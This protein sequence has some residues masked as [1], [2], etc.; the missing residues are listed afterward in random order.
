MII[1]ILKLLD[2]LSALADDIAT[3]TKIASEKTVAILGDDLAVNAEQ[4]TGFNQDKELKVIWEITKGSFKNKLILLPIIFILNYYLPI[5]ISFLLI[6]GGL[7]LL[8]EGIE[9]IYE[10]I[11]IK[12]LKKEKKINLLNINKLKKNINLEEKKIKSAIKTDFILSIEIIVITLGSV[13]NHPF[14]VQVISTTIVS[15][16]ATIF[17]YGIVALIVRIDNLGFYFIK[18]KAVKL[19]QFFIN[20]MSI[21]IKILSVVGTIAMILVGGNILTHKIELF[22]TYFLSFLPFIINEFILGI[23]IGSIIYILKFIIDKILLNKIK[24]LN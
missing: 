20:L 10:Y 1:G 9:K 11:E 3:T 23:I 18:H 12:F 4:A 24:I 16:L 2:N 15:I 17:V 19:G 7:Y 5:L 6:C 14:Y 13:I 8:Y 21:I 22:E